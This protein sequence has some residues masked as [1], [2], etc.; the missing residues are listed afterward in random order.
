MF[1]LFVQINYIELASS[2]H[3]NFC[4]KIGILNNAFV[5]YYYY[6]LFIYFQIIILV[7]LLKDN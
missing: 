3:A 2:F 4:Y 5:F 6:N 7:S 1:N